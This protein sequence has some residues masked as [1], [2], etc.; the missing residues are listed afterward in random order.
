MKTL[1]IELPESVTDAIRLPEAEQAGRLRLELAI[2]LYAQNLLSL[3][4]AAELAGND[5]H[6]FSHE[7]ARRCVSIHYGEEEFEEDLSYARSQ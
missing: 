4:K 6:L 5:S 2:A 1:Q 3:G 7:L